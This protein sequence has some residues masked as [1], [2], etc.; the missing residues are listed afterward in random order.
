MEGPLDGE[1]WTDMAYR[2][3]KETDVILSYWLHGAARRMVMNPLFGESGAD[4]VTSGDLFF[5]G[6]VNTDL[7]LVT[8]VPIIEEPPLTE[9]MVTFLKPFSPG[10]WALIIASIFVAGMVMYYLESDFIANNA[11]GDYRLPSYFLFVRQTIQVTIRCDAGQF[12]G[13][14]TMLQVSHYLI[15]PA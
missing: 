15:F 9:R 10:L 14:E 8:K 1:T 3:T 2:Y 6:H 13:A 11:S 12:E 7:V 5:L 4:G